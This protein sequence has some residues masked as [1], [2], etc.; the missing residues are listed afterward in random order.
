MQCNVVRWRNWIDLSIHH[1][2][3]PVPRVRP[4]FPFL[5]KDG[6]DS[7]YL[8]TNYRSKSYICMRFWI[9][10]GLAMTMAVTY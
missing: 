7:K 9:R 4:F 2:T 6:I 8:L 1:A 5:M 3:E 10:Y